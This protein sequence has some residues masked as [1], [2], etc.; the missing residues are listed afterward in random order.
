MN[1]LIVSENLPFDSVK[2]KGVTAVHIQLALVAREMSALG[3]KVAVLPIQMYDGHSSEQDANAS[4][5]AELD[6]WRGYTVLPPLFIRDTATGKRGSGVFRRLTRVARSLLKIIPMR[7]FYPSIVLGPEVTKCADRFGADIL[8]SFISP[9]ASGAMMTATE[10]PRVVFQGNID[11]VTDELRLEFDSLFRESATLSRSPIAR[12]IKRK[13]REGYIRCYE[14]SHRHV[15]LRSQ[16]ILN[17]SAGNNQYYED[18]GHPKVVYVGTTWSGPPAN[19]GQQGSGGV[20]DGS[21]SKPFKIIGHA[22]FLGMTASTFGL[23]YL[24]KYTMPALRQEMNGY[25][26]EVHIIGGGKATEVLR[27][28]LK[29]E[30]IVLRGYVKDLDSELLDSDVFLFLNNAGP[31]KSIFSRQIIAWAMGLCLVVHKGSLET[32]PE[33]DH[34]NN[35]LVGASA[36]ELASL[37]KRAC[38]D[39]DL[40]RK[41]R[42]GGRYTYDEHFTPAAISGKILSVMEEMVSTNSS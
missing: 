2:S 17:T 16:A 40:N 22:G 10:Y 34:G 31:L 11:F 7:E 33:L 8:L 30:N 35:V 24:L 12:L 23:E 36:P 4:L 3:H 39:R 29:Q 19:A 15:V 42:L 25:A 26:F 28:Y 18:I 32:L 20:S 14:M 21:A 41:L 27:P 5:S 1:I 38:L 13:V 6:E 37:V 9:H